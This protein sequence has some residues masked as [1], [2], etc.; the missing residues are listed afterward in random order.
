MIVDRSRLSGN[1]FAELMRHLIDDR[2]AVPIHSIGDPRFGVTRA[3]D[4]GTDSAERSNSR[5][6][7]VCTVISPGPVAATVPGRKLDDPM[8]SATN[9]DP[10]R[11]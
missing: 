2:R 7:P 10:G 11:S 1:A 6:G 8:N 5:P 9:L 4:R 3:D